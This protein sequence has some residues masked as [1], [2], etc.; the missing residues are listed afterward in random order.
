MQSFFSAKHHTSIMIVLLVAAIAL[1]PGGCRSEHGTSGFT[2]QP[3]PDFTLTMLDGSELN[4]NKLRGRPVLI[5]FWAPWCPGCLHNIPPLKELYARYGEVV[6]FIAPSSE[7]GRQALGQFVA[8]HAIPYPVGFANRRLLADYRI[9]GIP[10]TMLIDAEGLVRYHHI[11]Q[12]SSA[13]LDE[14]IREML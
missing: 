9:S 2:G 13:R 8:D 6:T 4:L 14:L 10:V 1:L 7:T 12:F 11:G 5:E 3:A